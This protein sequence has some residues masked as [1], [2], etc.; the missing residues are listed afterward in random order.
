MPDLGRWGV[1]D[2]LAVKMTRYSPYNYA[3]NNPISFIDPD[4]RQ[5]ED[6][7]RKDNKWT[8]DANITT[9][10]QAAGADAFA[11]NGSVI[12]DAKIG[13][14]GEAGYVRLN[15]GGTAE[16]MPDN[17]STALINFS[18]ETLGGTV[19]G[20]LQWE[21]DISHLGNARGDFYS[22]AGGAGVGQSSP[23]FRPERDKIKSLDG[24]MG[25]LLTPLAIGQFNPKMDRL[26]ALLG[27]QVQAFGLI[28][29][30]KGVQNDLKDKSF[31]GTI[32][33][34]V[35]PSKVGNRVV[36]YGMTGETQYIPFLNSRQYDSLRQKN[37]S[38]SAKYNR[39]MNKKSDSLLR[40]M[41][42]R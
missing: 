32:F 17:L 36:G 9:A 19:S 24:L 40:T 16:Y 34:G 3:Y 12:S 1:V 23:F 15:E 2:P 13:A 18:N 25:G 8:Y 42:P 39:L 7:I 14:D 31:Y 37:S 10:A 26:E 38:D 41:I 22:N 35:E 28:D 29:P 21:R 20:G 11:K 4:G 5:G 30:V 6:W 27:V 33:T